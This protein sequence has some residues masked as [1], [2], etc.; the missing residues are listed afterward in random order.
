MFLQ[1]TTELWLSSD[2]AIYSDQ[3]MQSSFSGYSLTLLSNP[4]VVFFLARSSSLLSP[5]KNRISYDIVN[6]DT[7]NAW[8]SVNN[9]YITPDD[10]TYIISVST[11]AYPKH[12]Q[13]IGIHVNIAFGNKYNL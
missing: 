10:G 1:K 3:Y 6:I 13:I 7:A 4:P 9:K 5:D 12:G 2:Y 11:G 8:D